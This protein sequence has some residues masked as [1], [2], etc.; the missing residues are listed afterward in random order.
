MC[1]IS[2]SSFSLVF[3]IAFPSF[4]KGAGDDVT[5]SSNLV[6]IVQCVPARILL[7]EHEWV[8]SN[9]L[10]LNLQ[11]KNESIIVVT[12]LPLSWSNSGLKLLVSISSVRW[13]DFTTGTG[14]PKF[15]FCRSGW[16]INVDQVL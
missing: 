16:T 10:P 11:T 4:V 14:Q 8:D 13:Q 12:Q 7:S 1:L 15:E 9:K 5:S 6:A 2:P 3:P